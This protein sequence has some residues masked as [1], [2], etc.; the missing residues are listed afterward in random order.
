MTFTKRGTPEQ[1]AFEVSGLVDL[2][3]AGAR[4]A[5]LED[6]GEDYLQTTTIEEVSPSREAARHLGAMLAHM[7]RPVD[8]FWGEAPRSF[9]YDTGFMGAAPLPFP[10]TPPRSWGEFY[11]TYRIT[12]YLKASRDNGSLSRGDITLIETLC[13]KLRDGLAE[14]GDD[15]SIIHGDLWWGNV[16]FDKD[17]PVLI[18][19]ACHTGHRESDLA[20]LAFFGATGLADILDS[21][22][23][24]FPLVDGWEERVSLHQLHIALVHTAVFGSAYG[25]QTMGLVASYV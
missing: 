5:N 19:P 22:N 21:Y 17:G 15:P 12:P 18:D 9:P 20:Q 13:E 7:H 24:A 1:I 16:L 6:I 14:T 2:Y 11:A 8:R 25:R 23:E 10:T 3:R 4:V